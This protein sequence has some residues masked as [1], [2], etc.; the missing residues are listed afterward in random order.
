MNIEK[1][2][3]VQAGKFLLGIDAAVIHA[4]HPADEYA[5]E[6][7]PDT[8]LLHLDAFFG[9]QSL[10]AVATEVLE[11]VEEFVLP[12]L[13]VDRVI[14][15]INAPDHFEPLP[16]LYPE[17]A[18]CCCPQI[19]LHEEQVF[20]LFE[21]GK[22]KQVCDQLYTG[23]GFITLEELV[24]RVEQHVPEEKVDKAVE[25]QIADPVQPSVEEPKEREEERVLQAP[26]VEEVVE[27][28]VVEELKVEDVDQSVDLSDEQPEE[29]DTV[30]E[31]PAPVVEKPVPPAMVDDVEEVVEPVDDPVALPEEKEEPE[32]SQPPVAAQKEPVPERSDENS[33]TGKTEKP[34]AQIN[35]ELFQKIVNWTIGQ[36]IM[37]DRNEKAVINASD[38]PPGLIR[39]QGLSLA[40]G[41]LRN[42][43]VQ[44]II[45][46]TVVKCE[47]L[48][49]KS[50][51]VLRK[52]YG[53]SS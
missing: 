31:A 44:Y 40:N 1:I 53:V 2:C 10:E 51:Q 34:T 21:P 39:E 7:E 50:V 36:Y 13:L 28:P 20:L 48:N 38:L 29:E 11:L 24:T 26:V 23:H 46:K 14:G 12:A 45:N 17:L 3:L 33:D 37:C 8:P 30:V 5:K 22:I 15:E 52:K 47:R 18:E 41:R 27:P 42:D 9:Q 16:L 35:D 32:E 25:P 19:F 49:E 43:T 4:T 6:R